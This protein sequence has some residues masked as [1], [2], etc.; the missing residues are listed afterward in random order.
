MMDWV[1]LKIA[2]PVLAIIA[3][4]MVTAICKTLAMTHAWEIELHKKLVASKRMRA[5]YLASVAMQNDV[6]VDFLDDADQR[7]A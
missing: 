2:L 6:N 1:T 3:Y 5:E 4:L 7:G